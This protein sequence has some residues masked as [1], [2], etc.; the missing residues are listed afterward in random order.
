MVEPRVASHGAVQFA[1]QYRAT[2]MSAIGTKRTCTSAPPMSVGK[3]DIRSF[4]KGTCQSFVLDQPAS[5]KFPKWKNSKQAGSSVRK[6]TD[7][8]TLR[9]LDINPRRGH[10]R[11]L[12]S[13]RKHFGTTCQMTH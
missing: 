1:P 13:F 11:F 8:T 6:K 4:Q 10:A 12:T 3:A 9:Y 7:N 5:K 2:V